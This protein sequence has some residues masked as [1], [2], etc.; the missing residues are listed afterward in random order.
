MTRISDDLRRVKSASRAGFS[1]LR[2]TVLILTDARVT[3]DKQRPPCAAGSHASAPPASWFRGVRPAD[4]RG[5]EGGPRATASLAPPQPLRS[6]L[7]PSLEGL[8]RVLPMVAAGGR[9][10]VPLP[11]RCP[12]P[13]ST[14]PRCGRPRPPWRP[15]AG[16][17]QLLPVLGRLPPA[18][19]RPC[20]PAPSGSPRGRPVHRASHGPVP[21]FGAGAPVRRQLRAGVNSD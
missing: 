4:P 6:P 3:G 5:G 13:P 14:E 9:A 19:R 10:A 7:G 17:P 2:R 12:R 21:G 18:G 16:P 20:I 1:H 11:R 8:G 15:G